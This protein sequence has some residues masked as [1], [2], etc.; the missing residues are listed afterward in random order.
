MREHVYYEA[1]DGE[2]FSSKE[3]CEAYEA[4]K[5][6]SPESRALRLSSFEFYPPMPD[7]IEETW[8]WFLL[9]SKDDLEAIKQ[10]FLNAYATADEYLGEISYPCWVLLRYDEFGNGTIMTKQDV[11]LEYLGFLQDIRVHISMCRMEKREEKTE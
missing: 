11:E 5:N 7:G 4:E 8:R 10:V 2:T 3:E 6:E 1:F 9:E